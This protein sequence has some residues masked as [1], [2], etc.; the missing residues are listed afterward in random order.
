MH[1]CNKWQEVVKNIDLLAQM[2]HIED[3]F[4]GL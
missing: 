4:Q 3:E 2:E 1:E